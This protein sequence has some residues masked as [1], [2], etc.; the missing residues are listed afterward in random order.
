MASPIFCFI[1]DT[2]K[3]DPAVE[4]IFTSDNIKEIAA[5]NEKEQYRMDDNLKN[6]LIQILSDYVKPDQQ[7]LGPENS[8]RKNDIVKKCE[9]LLY[10]LYVVIIFLYVFEIFNRSVIFRKSLWISRSYEQNWSTEE[11]TYVMDFVHWPIQVVL[12]N[13]WSKLQLWA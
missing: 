4:N 5:L 11:R 6:H 8:S 2:H 12:K 9:E 13:L 1:L 7:S 10:K 3:V